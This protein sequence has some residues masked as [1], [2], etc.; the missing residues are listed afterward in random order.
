MLEV[1][2]LRKNYPDFNIQLD[3]NIKQ[4]E[5][6]SLLGPSGCGKTTTLRLLAGLERCDSGT[7][8]FRKKDITHLQPQKRRFGLV[9]QDYALFPHLNV[10]ENILYGI[11][12]KNKSEKEK[13]LLE[14]LDLFQLISLKERSIRHLSGGEQQRVALARALAVKPEILLLDEPFAA[15]DPSLR[16][17]LR[18]ELKELQKKLGLT[19]VFVTHNQ[20]EALSLSDR[21]ALLQEGR[22]IQVAEPFEIYTKPKTEYVAGF[23]GKVN[24]LELTVCRKTLSWG[25]TTVDIDLEDGSYLLAI[26]PEHLTAGTGVKGTVTSSSYLG[27]ATLYVVKTVFGL[28]HY[29]ELD[30]GSIK[31][32]GTEIELSLKKAVPVRKTA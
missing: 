26:R 4:G 30:S 19:I 15:L 21:V 10:R 22:I 9:F 12:Q 6:F 25:N 3:F 8:L 20:E 5:F 32:K 28:L 27:F 16:Q 18:E 29:L 31:P 24:F 1:I 2:D 13:R 17:S 14:M 23:F 7:I 11:N